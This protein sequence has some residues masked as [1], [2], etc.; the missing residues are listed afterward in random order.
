VVRGKPSVVSP[1]V[2]E[3]PV[4]ANPETVASALGNTGS[5]PR[6]AERLGVAQD[7]VQRREAERQETDRLAEQQLE[8]QRHEATRLAEAQLE[9]QRREAARMAAAEQ[10]G[11]RLR[12][13]QE[14]A[15][16]QERL[17]AIGRQ[18][19]EEADRR[20]AAAAMRPTLPLSLSNARRVKL[21]GRTHANEE[22]VRYAEA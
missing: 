7:K 22:L 20:D 9:A 3:P 18:L 12:A 1:V 17:R 8:A 19:D 5:V 15:K 6:D 16:R 4:D 11:A 2:P 21:Y 10:E 14:E 13:A